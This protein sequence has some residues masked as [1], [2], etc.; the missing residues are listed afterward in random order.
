MPLVSIEVSQ[1]IAKKI[2][3]LAESGVFAITKGSATLHFDQKELKSIK[4]ELYTYPQTYAQVD[5]LRV[6]PIL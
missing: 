4:T 3:F 2:R 6:V 5:N 1:D